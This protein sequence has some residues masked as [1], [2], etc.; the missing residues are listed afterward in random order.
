MHNEAT[1]PLTGAIPAAAY[2][3]IRDGWLRN[4][5]YEETRQGASHMSQSKDYTGYRG[6][7]ARK[8]EHLRRAAEIVRQRKQQTYAW[9]GVQEGHKVL[10]VGCG[11]GMDTIPLAHIVGPTG[12]VVGIDID[13]AM[14]SKADERAKEAGVADWVEH[15][16]VDASSMPFEDD[17]FDAQHS[18]RLFSHL[19]NAE[20]VLAEMLRVAK[21]G[22]LIAVIETDMA[23][24]SSDTEEDDVER[25][26]IPFWA[27]IQENPYAGRKLYRLAVLAGLVEVTMR[28][29]PLSGH[30]LDMWRYGIKSADVEAAAL[31]AG[32]VTQEELDRH[33]A[34]QERLDRMG[35]FYASANFITVVSRKPS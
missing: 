9:M 30:S 25:R 23:T 20:Q 34:S 14:L 27:A 32:A 12:L 22:G 13:E 33:N 6:D 35:A 19:T 3:A 7:T 8:E 10:D 21:P 26:L 29:S 17:T 1:P 15:R 11:A 28:I 16:L 31:A 18:E 4:D 5:E 2:Q 24:A